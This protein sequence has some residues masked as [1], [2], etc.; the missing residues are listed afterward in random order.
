[1]VDRFENEAREL[2]KIRKR[3]C[4]ITKQ[5]FTPWE[6]SDIEERYISKTEAELI[7]RISMPPGKDSSVSS[8]G[9]TK[10]RPSS[11]AA[12]LQTHPSYTTG[13]FDNVALRPATAAGSRTPESPGIAQRP[14]TQAAGSRRQWQRTTQEE[15]KPSDIH[16]QP[17]RLTLSTVDGIADGKSEQIKRPGIVQGTAA[18][19]LR[20][21]VSKTVVCFITVATFQFVYIV[22]V[23][24]MLRFSV[25]VILFSCFVKIS[26]RQT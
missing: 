26:A 13:V 22:T 11:A 20:S 9:K 23:G 1:M 17:R 7:E 8:K 25:S 16:K 19:V 10:I 24:D 3:L 2:N 12:N 4:T 18:Q 6:S 15:A 14:A 5:W 21:K